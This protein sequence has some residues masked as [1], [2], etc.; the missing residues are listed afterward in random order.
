MAEK[1]AICQE[2]VG[3]LWPLIDAGEVKPITHEVLPVE[4]AADAHRKMEEGGI[5][6]K[7]VLKM[8]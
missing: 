5:L 2:L 3:K 6:G 4:Q 1:T 7:L 8:P